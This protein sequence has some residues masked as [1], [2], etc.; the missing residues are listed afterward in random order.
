MAYRE[1]VSGDNVKIVGHWS[2][3]STYINSSKN[4][5]GHIV[6][7]VKILKSSSMPYLLSNDYYWC[8]KG[9]RALPRK[10]NG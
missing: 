8:R 10:K 7:V 1:L 4:M 2:S 9:L 5:I 3:D 6:E